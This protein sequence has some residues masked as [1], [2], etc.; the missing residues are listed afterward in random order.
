MKGIIYGSIW[1]HYRVIKNRSLGY[2]LKFP[3]IIPGSISFSMVFSICFSI[4][5][6]DT[7][8][9]Y[10]Q[11]ESGAADVEKGHKTYN[12]FENQSEPARW[13]LRV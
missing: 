2:T 5:K 6:G 12:T 4:I 8:S 3:H 13:A 9:S 11:E 7:W 10:V 1:E